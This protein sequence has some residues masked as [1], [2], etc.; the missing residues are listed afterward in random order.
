MLASLRKRDI[1]PCFLSSSLW[2]LYFFLLSGMAL[3]GRRK[4]SQ[5]EESITGCGMAEPSEAGALLLDLIRMSSNAQQNSCLSERRAQA[6][7]SYIFQKEANTAPFEKS[8]NCHIFYSRATKLFRCFLP[9]G[10]L[11]KIRFVDEALCAFCG[12]ACIDYLDT[13]LYSTCHLRYTGKA[14]AAINALPPLHSLLSYVYAGHH[15]SHHVTQWRWGFALT[16]YVNIHTHTHIVHRYWAES[17]HII[18]KD[19]FWG[20]LSS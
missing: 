14:K 15:I 19:W 17:L 18:Q 3:I 4:I 1:A 5:P 2:I 7:S 6:S 16:L 8:L 20:G 11:C 9:H 13:D 10:N 12:R